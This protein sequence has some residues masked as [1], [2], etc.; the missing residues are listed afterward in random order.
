MIN[1]PEL[2]HAIIQLSRE[3]STPFY[4]YDTA[5]IRQHCQTFLD[6][7]YAHK[8]IH[9]ASM[10][11]AHPDFLRT[12]K[13]AGIRVF[14]NSLGH[15]QTIRDAGF[16]GE[17]IV[18]TASAMTA[19]AMQEVVQCGAQL[20]LDSPGQL[21]L[22]QKLFPAKPVGLRCNIGD[23][24]KPYSNYAG[25]FIGSQSRLGFADAELQAI[26]DKD[27]IRGLHLYVGTDI[28]DVK[29]FLDCYRELIAL[30][31]LFPKL[32]YLN[33][34]GGFGVA[35]DGSQTFDFAAYG[36]AV[37]TLMEEVS[38]RRGR[39]V[40]M[41]LEPGRIIGGAAGYFVCRVTDV[42]PRNGQMLIGVDASSAQFSR[43]LM[44]PE[45]AHN[46]VV[47]LRQGQLLQDQ[48]LHTASVYGCSTYS[49]DFLVRDTLLPEVVP[50]DVLILGHAGSYMASSYT[51]F[52]G[53]VK[54]PEFFV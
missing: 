17:E 10:A 32:E 47:V 13:E 38:H 4:L 26:A 6:I 30:S 20:N 24:V 27:L 41:Y 5:L 22:W 35:E 1:H 3:Q 46:P 25:C 2:L 36:G 14:V 43:P 29:Y 50:G 31:E 8:S 40:R 48:P 12:V 52:L 18:F 16:Q 44:Y 54:P 28:F 53:F 49:R 45:C 51:Q 11:N 15:L 7:P 33:F 21:A 39:S 42:K 37:T 34:G 19:Q 23:K 9:F